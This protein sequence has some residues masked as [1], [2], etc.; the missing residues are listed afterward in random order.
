LTQETHIIAYSIPRK[1]SKGHPA[2]QCVF[3]VSGRTLR[4]QAD[5]LVVFIVFHRP[6][7]VISAKKNLRKAPGP[8]S[9]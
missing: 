4:M 9:P 1:S 3:I 2:N 6:L 5:V 7:V 8:L